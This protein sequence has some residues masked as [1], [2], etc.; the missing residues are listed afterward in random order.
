MSPSIAISKVNEIFDSNV[1]MRSVQA[2]CLGVR[3]ARRGLRL[4]QIDLKRSEVMRKIVVVLV[5][6]LVPICM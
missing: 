1:R 3:I 4:Y 5:S 2:V 6:L